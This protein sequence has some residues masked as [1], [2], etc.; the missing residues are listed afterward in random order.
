MRKKTKDHFQ[1]ELFVDSSEAPV[2]LAV[3]SAVDID[4]VKE[5]ETSTAT[6]EPAA[7]SGV[8]EVATTDLKTDAISTCCGAAEGST[9]TEP[10]VMTSDKAPVAV[11]NHTTTETQSRSSAPEHLV[12]EVQPE[13]MTDTVADS[14]K[15]AR[16]L[17]VPPL[18]SEPA[19]MSGALNLESTDNKSGQMQAEDCG[20]ASVET[21]VQEPASG[22]PE[23]RSLSPST[24]GTAIQAT[25]LGTNEPSDLGNAQQATA[26][27][28]DQKKP[29]RKPLLPIT[30]GAEPM[31]A[32]GVTL[33]AALATAAGISELQMHSAGTSV[34]LNPAILGTVKKNYIAHDPQY[35]GAL[36]ERA[37]NPALLGHDEYL[38]GERA[39]KTIERA[40]D[41]L[42]E[43]RAV[44]TDADGNPLT[45]QSYPEIKRFLASCGA[46]HV[47]LCPGGKRQLCDASGNE[48]HS[49]L[50][51]KAVPA[52]KRPEQNDQAA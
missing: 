25:C 43:I 38:A 8:P 5:D 45:L 15:D 10:T 16:L 19:K 13:L 1:M 3:S 28:N 23:V 33:Y 18:D 21:L 47:R 51:R 11:I 4:S 7:N 9:G 32:R 35:K 31:Q 17:G 44:E 48:V 14:A 29:G 20:S 34:P 40:M 6:P 52:D 27:R 26:K 37:G 46:T 24:P 30:T 41:D 42:V 12:C 22:A 36:I 50:K 2:A 39:R 49:H